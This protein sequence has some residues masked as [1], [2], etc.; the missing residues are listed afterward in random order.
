MFVTDG[1][2]ITLP[3]TITVHIDAKDEAEYATVIT[4]DAD[5]EQA[6]IEP[7][8]VNFIQTPALTAEGIAVQKYGGLIVPKGKEATAITL[9]ADIKG[10]KYKASSTI[11]ASTVAVDATVSLAKH[12]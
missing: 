9:E 2:S 3:E 5:F 1:T 10:T 8:S 11:D 12:G 4:M 6:G 7:Q